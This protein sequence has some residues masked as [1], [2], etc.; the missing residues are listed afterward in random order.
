MSDGIMY[1]Q[2]IKPNT[3]CLRQHSRGIVSFFYGLVDILKLSISIFLYQSVTNYVLCPKVRGGCRNTCDLV[4]DTQV[5]C[6]A[7]GRR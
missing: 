1:E 7:G 6:R 4:E 3:S 5:T 2:F